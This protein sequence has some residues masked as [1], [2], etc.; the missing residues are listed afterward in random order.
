MVDLLKNYLVGNYIEPSSLAEEQRK[1]ET[2][3]ALKLAYVALSRP[4][5]LIAIAI[6]K[7]LVDQDF[8][9][10]LKEFGWVEYQLQAELI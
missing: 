10:C 9:E 6:P 4:T 1:K 5:H 2:Y 3:K 7:S 8:V